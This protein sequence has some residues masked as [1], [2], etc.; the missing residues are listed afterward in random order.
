[1]SHEIDC[2]LEVDWL[3]EVSPV[4]LVVDDALLDEVGVDVDAQRAHLASPGP[5]DQILALRT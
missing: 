5:A 3:G 1:M 2:T 4:G